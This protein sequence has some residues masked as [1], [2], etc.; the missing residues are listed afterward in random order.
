MNDTVKE[1]G[2]GLAIAVGISA[3]TLAVALITYGVL[4]VVD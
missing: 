1:V 3:Y 2:M 4:R